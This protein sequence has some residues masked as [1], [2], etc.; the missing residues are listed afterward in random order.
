MRESATE[1]VY[2]PNGRG[3]RGKEINHIGINNYNIVMNN[4]A[5]FSGQAG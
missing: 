3:A 1:S 2:T 5:K 4:D